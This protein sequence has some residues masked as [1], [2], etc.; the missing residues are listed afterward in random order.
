MPRLVGG[1]CSPLIPRERELFIYDLLCPC[2]TTELEMPK[3]SLV[4]LAEWQGGAPCKSCSLNCG[5]LWSSLLLLQ[6]SL[7]ELHTGLRPFP[8]LTRLCL[9]LQNSPC[10]DSSP[11]LTSSPALHKC[12]FRADV[13]THS[14]AP[15]PCT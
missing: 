1:A 7:A 11:G 6:C 9:C 8:W 14:T 2:C 13:A 10:G 12:C 3:V 15:L 4:R 5:V